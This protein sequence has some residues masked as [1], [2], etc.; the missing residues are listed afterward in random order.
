MRSSRVF[1]VG[2][3]HPL[4]PRLALVQKKHRVLQNIFISNETASVCYTC[5]DLDSLLPVSGNGYVIEE[6]SSL[7]NHRYN[8]G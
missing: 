5:F 6:V 7:S 3:G 8:H 2:R 4:S 1:V